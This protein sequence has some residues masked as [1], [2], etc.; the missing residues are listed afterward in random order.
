MMNKLK[1]GQVSLQ[2]IVDQEVVFESNG[3]WL[4]PLFDLEEFIVDHP[5]PMA[6]ALVRDKVIGKAAA[7]LLIRLGAEC[8]H[9]ELMSEL[10]V[11]T[12]TRVNILHTYDRLVQRIDCQTE[13]LLS[14]INDPEQ[15]YQILCTRAGRC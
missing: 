13:A 6:Q 11:E 12:L 8:L 3:K 10:A 9:G 14:E 7:L 4:Y 2:V 15:A 5:L 1:S